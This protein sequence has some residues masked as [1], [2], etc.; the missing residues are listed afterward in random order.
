VYD[1]QGRSIGPRL[2]HIQEN[3][4][5]EVAHRVKNHL[6]SLQSMLTLQLRESEGETK[7]ISILTDS[8]NRIKSMGRLY[9]RLQYDPSVAT[10]G[11]RGYLETLI[12]D[13][14]STGGR[15]EYVDVHL[16]AEDLQ[17]SIEQGAS[18]GLILNELATNSLKHALPE[19]R[20]G[21][22]SVSVRSSGTHIEARVSDSGPGVSPDYLDQT[23]ERLGM[24]IVTAIVGQHGGEFILGNPDASLFLVR[25]PRMLD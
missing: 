1:M 16:D 4:L 6:N 7:V 8:I 5:R 20:P 17:I 11:L 24:Q 25:L 13:I 23:R 18:I 10:I 19:G 15:E 9:D 22:I 12:S 2:D 14:V 3:S 21:W